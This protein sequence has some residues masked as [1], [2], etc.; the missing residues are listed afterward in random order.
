MQCGYLVESAGSRGVQ[1]FSAADAQ[2]KLAGTADLLGKRPPGDVGR[3][4]KRTES[5]AAA[6]ERERDQYQE[7][8]DRRP[9]KLPRQPGQ[10]GMAVLGEEMKLVATA[11]LRRRDEQPAIVIV[12]Q[13]ARDERRS[14]DHGDA[15]LA[16]FHAHDLQAPCVA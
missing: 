2:R 4:G 8:T 7:Q 15:A 16:Q 11:Q 9:P 1:R 12:K 10:R 14:I 13:A 6:P 3:R 5:S